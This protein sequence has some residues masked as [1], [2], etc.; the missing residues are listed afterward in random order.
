[1]CILINPRNAFNLMK[2]EALK[3]IE[4]VRLLVS[5][6]QRFVINM[7][8]TPIFFSML[9]RTT[10]EPIGSS[11]V[12]VPNSTG[13]TFGVTITVTVTANGDMLPPL[14]VFKGK[15]KGRISR[16]FTSYPAGAVYTVQDHAWM[17]ESMMQH[18]VSR[19]DQS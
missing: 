4:E 15:P 12:N 6:D 7:D 11:T 8:Q 14:F 13:S 3:W 9:P 5:R 19:F 16:E 2:A 10:L 17:D 18:K 1:V